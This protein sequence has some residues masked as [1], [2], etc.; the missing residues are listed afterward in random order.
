MQKVESLYWISLYSYTGAKREI[1]REHFKKLKL[2][3]FLGL[4]FRSNAKRF[5]RNQCSDKCVKNNNATF[6]YD[7][8]EMETLDIKFTLDN[9]ESPP[10]C[11]TI[12][13]LAERKETL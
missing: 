3:R 8:R 10:E 4:A 13:K 1:D 6:F 5:A 9:V 12:K 7:I 11:Q 2:F